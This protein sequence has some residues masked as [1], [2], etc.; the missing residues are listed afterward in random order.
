MSEGA[1]SVVL[2]AP[3][4]DGLYLGTGVPSVLTNNGRR[5]LNFSADTDL[6]ETMS[7]SFTGSKTTVFDRNYN[8]QSSLTVFSTVLQLHFG[9]GDMK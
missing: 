1:I 8:R 7:F 5:Q 2:D 6:S 3:S 4:L 9:A